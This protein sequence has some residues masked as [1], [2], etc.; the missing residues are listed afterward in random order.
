M[1]INDLIENSDTDKKGISS[2]ASSIYKPNKNKSINDGYR[3]M[4][5]F[6]RSPLSPQPFEDKLSVTQSLSN[7]YYRPK[8][9]DRPLIG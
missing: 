2:R 8:S 6:E 5:S 9:M 4:R 3:T 7:P 1:S